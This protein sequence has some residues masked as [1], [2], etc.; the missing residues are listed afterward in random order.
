MVAASICV[1]FGRSPVICLENMITH[2]R[3]SP[4]KGAR[5]DGE[6]NAIAPTPPEGVMRGHHGREF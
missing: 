4:E 6:A 1:L 5:R 2:T 3:V